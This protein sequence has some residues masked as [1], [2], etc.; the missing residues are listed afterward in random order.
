MDGD[1][2]TRRLRVSV[3]DTRAN[4]GDWPP[5]LGVGDV[6]LVHADSLESV[7]GAAPDLAVVFAS[8]AEARRV[9]DEFAGRQDAAPLTLF[10]E[11]G[12]GK[13]P[14]ARLM[15]ALVRGKREWEGTFD[16]MED[17]LLILG[18]DGVVA[19]ANLALARGVNR[20]VS[21]TAA[22][23]YLELLGEPDP[24]LGDPI[25]DSLQD[26]APRSQEAAFAM[27][28]KRRLVT[29]CLLQGAEGKPRQLVVVLKDLTE[30]EE[31]RSRLLQGAHLAS[32]GRLAG[33]VAHEIN[34]PL[35]SIALRTERLLKTAQDPGL[36]SLPAFR[37]FPRH[38]QAIEADVFRCKNIIAAL[39][40]FSRSR[41]PE[42][43]ETDLNGLAE[44]ALELVG[45]QMK[46]KGV[47]LEQ[48]IQPGLPKILAD[49]GRL[50]QAIVG[51]LMN[52]L[53]AVAAGGHVVV[54]TGRE[55]PERVFLTVADDGAG[56]PPED[57]DRIF[58]PFF[59][60]KPVGS[61]MGLGLAL[62]HG[63][64]ASLGGEIRVES[65]PGQGTR[66]TLLL[67]VSGA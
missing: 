29:T 34:T 51:L 20:A 65:A 21:D 24:K 18:Q 40:E 67:P 61:G 33:G 7:F 28:P 11:G 8:P 30:L 45:Y 22:R 5:F 55:G 13:H 23:H 16:A 57:R 38:L 4:A 26:G 19:R 46:V 36:S 27:L 9:A 60:T 32:V 37:D 39:L 15:E 17:P 3:L 62:C 2:A 53:D 43:R 50:H 66:I 48:R 25:G 56:I 41:P 44:R 12:D 64:V 47:E 42:T 35:A 52:A 6:D 58:S 54:E 63:V 1:H 49:D 10:V 14:Q 31:R 59:T